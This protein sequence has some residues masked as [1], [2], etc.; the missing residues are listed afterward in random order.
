MINKDHHH[1]ESHGEVASLDGPDEN[2]TGR[3]K[4]GDMLSIL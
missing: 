2:F 3:V 1:V 4:Q